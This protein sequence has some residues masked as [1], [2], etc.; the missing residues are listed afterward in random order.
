VFT[1][2]HLRVLAVT[3]M[4]PT[5]E[6]A[7]FGAFVASQMRSIAALG[8]EV[9]VHFVN[10]RR[11]DGEYLV[12]PLKIHRRLRDCAYDIVHA[13][14][15]LT[16]FVAG[17]HSRPLVVSFCG[18]DLL[19][20][21]DG[22]G[23][24]RL[25]SRLVVQLSYLA[26]MRADAIIC[27]SIG[28][29]DSLPRQIDRQRAVVLGNGVDTRLFRPGDRNAAR[30]RLGLSEHERLVIFPHSQRQRHVKRFDLAE[31]ATQLLPTFGTAAR[32]WMVN[33]V[34]PT[35]MAL[36]YQA[37]DCFLMTSDH[38]GSP[39]TVK[40]ALCCG[41]PV[42]SVDVGDVRRWTDLAPGCRIVE[43][44]PRAI[45]AGLAAILAG[46][47]LVDGKAVRQAV[48]LERVA[49][50]VVDVYRGALEKRRP[51]GD[52]VGKGRT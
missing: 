28:L 18:D 32:L 6:D 4:Y 27:K 46:P 1:D 41:L 48:S 45:A 17:F 43:R 49:Q 51:L 22:R 34:A 16:G 30:K 29:R 26:A 35:Q 3:N 40:E 21:P 25:K 36:H 50:Q 31:V 20:T 8:L 10:G 44:D 7:T 39:N 37:A 13:H 47:R 14:Y 42:V 33:G 9:D 2:K 24:T 11:G 38:E 23:G 5:A 19:G 52:G 15:G 12:A